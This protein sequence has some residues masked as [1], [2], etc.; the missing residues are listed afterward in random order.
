MADSNKI[1]VNPLRTAAIC[2]EDDC[3]LWDGHIV[4]ATFPL[5]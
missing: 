2:C 4:D 3:P 5:V 1:T